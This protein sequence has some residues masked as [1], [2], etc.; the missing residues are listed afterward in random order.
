MAAVVVETA[1]AR[2]SRMPYGPMI[3]HSASGVPG[4]DT[5]TATWKATF[6]FA[7]T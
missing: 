2:H 5:F 7:L 6:A 1:S 3:R 4:P